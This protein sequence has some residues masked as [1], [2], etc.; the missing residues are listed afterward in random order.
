MRSAISSARRAS[1][2]STRASARSGRASRARFGVHA[3]TNLALAA[4]MHLVYAEGDASLDPVGMDDLGASLV[5]LG[6]PDPA[7]PATA[8]DTLDVDCDGLLGNYDPTDD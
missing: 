2:T 6:V 3:D 1:P 4:R 8:A 5:D 7:S